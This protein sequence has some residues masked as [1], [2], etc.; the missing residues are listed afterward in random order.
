M[1]R[2]LTATGTMVYGLPIKPFPDAEVWIG[3]QYYWNLLLKGSTLTSSDKT[4]LFEIGTVYK[5]IVFGS[6]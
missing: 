1:P 3:R 4:A 5:F 2:A 6:D